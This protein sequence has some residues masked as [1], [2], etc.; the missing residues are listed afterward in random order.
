MNNKILIV[1]DEYKMRFIIRDFLK[2]EG[3]ECIEASDGEEAIQCFLENKDIDLVLLDIMMPKLDGWETCQ[4]LRQ[5]SDD[6]PILM[7][8]AKSENEDI[9]KGLRLGAD[10]YVSKPFHMPILIERIKALLRRTQKQTEIQ[11]HNLY[12]NL[13]GHIVK[14]DGE[15]IDLSTKEYELL[16]YLLNH[17]NI[18]LEREEL[19]QKVWNYEYVGDGRTVDTHIKTLRNKLG[20][21][22]DMIKTVW[23]F[24][25][26]LEV[27]EHESY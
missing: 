4:K 20:S 12:I 13:T 6:I 1:D 11:I 17:K 25:Y 21:A 3:F 10:D 14:V 18:A 22:G 5:Y 23:G 8:T 19:I 27:D 7:L 24:G 26:K 16:V 9:V 15:V 2:R